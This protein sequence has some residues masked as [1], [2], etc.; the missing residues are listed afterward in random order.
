MTCLWNDLSANDGWKAYQAIW[1]LAAAPNLTVPF[2]SKHI[3]SAPG[4]DAKYIARLIADLDCDEFVLRV[5]ASAELGTLGPSIELTLRNK[6][7]QKPSPELRR[8]IKPLLR[9]SEL[10]ASRAIEVLEHISNAEAKELLKLLAK[11]QP[12]SRLTEEA[13]ACLRRLNK[14]AAAKDQ[15]AETGTYRIVF[16]QL[17]WLAWKPASNC[18]SALNECAC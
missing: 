11:R 12:G 10:W 15:G 3:T 13:E 2:L 4:L 14:R 9:T 16:G 5:K 1:S 17:L 7:A 18:R 6:L 8:R